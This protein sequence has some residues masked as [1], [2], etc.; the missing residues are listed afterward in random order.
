MSAY[1]IGSLEV[2]KKPLV[3]FFIDGLRYDA[4]EYMPFLNSM[5]YK[6]PL[7]TILGYSNAC[8]AT[9]YTGVYPNRHHV[10][11]VW[12][13]SKRNF[14]RIK[15]SYENLSL[16]DN[17]IGR[18]LIHKFKLQK[19]KV[20]SVFGIPR[21]VHLPIRYWKY[22]DLSERKRPDEA[23]Y[24]LNINTIFDLLRENDVTFDIVGL[25]YKFGRESEA[26][27]NYE[28]N[29]VKQ[30]TYFFIGDVDYVSHR[31]GQFS[32][33]G[34][35]LLRKLDRLI[36]EKLL[37]FEKK[38]VKPLF[39]IFSDHGHIDV[40]YRINPYEY[41]KR[42][43]VNLNSLF[44]IVDVNFLRI[45][46]ENEQKKEIVLNLLSEL[47]GFIIS[48]EIAKKYHVNMPDN[49]YGDLIFY[50]DKPYV[51]SRTIWG[52][53]RSEKSN[54]GYLPDYSDSYGLLV[55]NIDF[56]S[57]TN[58]SYLDLTHIYSILKSILL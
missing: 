48:E 15:P 40:L 43:G 42:R 51:F 22:L 29:Q 36:Q 12:M 45:W 5:P 13:R 18:I 32:S 50:L 17:V 44:H 38:G 34:K 4:L 56:T 25:G 47:P 54:H 46:F 14:L 27:E 26:V 8:H 6:V 3:T 1:T 53:S 19:I 20:S 7:K 35:N 52:F 57:L 28:I 31:Y 21:I 33:Q 10:W 24:L 30:W 9:M 41:F 2:S 49:R 58:S 16:F 37:Q 11:F 39:F 23:R 55:G